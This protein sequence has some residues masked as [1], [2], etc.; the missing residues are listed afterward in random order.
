MSVDGKHL[1]GCL[2]CTRPKIFKKQ[3]VFLHVGSAFWWGPDTGTQVL[4]STG[5]WTKVLVGARTSQP[6]P[7][8]VSMELA[9]THS[10]WLDSCGNPSGTHSLWCSRTLRSFPG[11]SQGAD[12][13]RGSPGDLLHGCLGD[14]AA[15][16][17]TLPGAPTGLFPPL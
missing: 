3:N 1:T 8:D 6:L 14:A 17:S 9:A 10:C 7:L 4:V 2:A 16:M 13:T 11:L 12:E 5:A 15:G